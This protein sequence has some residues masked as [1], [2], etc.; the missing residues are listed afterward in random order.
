MQTSLYS[1]IASS[2][3]KTP[4]YNKQTNSYCYMGQDKPNHDVVI[5]GW[6]D[7]Y[8]KENFNVDL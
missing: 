6:D 3:T 7:N 1:T 5:I 4:Y 8:P 2:K